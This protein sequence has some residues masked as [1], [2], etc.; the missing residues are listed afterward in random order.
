M[1]VKAFSLQNSGS[2]NL[3]KTVDLH[4]LKAFLSYL[5]AVFPLIE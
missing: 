4:K 1:N 3:P 2:T 5:Q